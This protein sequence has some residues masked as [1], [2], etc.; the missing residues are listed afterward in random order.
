MPLLIHIAAAISLT[1]VLVT[2]YAFLTA[3][4]AIQDEEGFHA[5]KPDGAVESESTLRDLK[6]RD[7]NAP[8]FVSAH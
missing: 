4:D 1:A 2:I 5:I 3:P 6:G 7:R 8:P